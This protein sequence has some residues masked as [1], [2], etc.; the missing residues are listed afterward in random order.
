MQIS[1]LLTE[2][3]AVSSTI[4]V[5]LMV[6]VTVILAAVVGAFAMGLFSQTTPPP[7]QTGFSVEYDVSGS[8]PNTTNVTMA[9]GS[10]VRTSRLKVTI[11]GNST[12]ERGSGQ[13]G[14][15]TSGWSTKKIESGDTLDIAEDGK[16]IQSGDEIQVIWDTADTSTVLNDWTIS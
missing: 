4:G 2:K 15:K 16:P 1:A 5:V 11:D 3:R 9:T 10:E 7:P 6:A 13:T 14:F 12:W 8:G